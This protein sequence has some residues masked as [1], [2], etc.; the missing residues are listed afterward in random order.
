MSETVLLWIGSLIFAIIGSL[1][2]RTLAGI[3]ANQRL[4]GDAL[5]ESL[6]ESRENFKE[7]FTRINILEVDHAAIKAQ[8]NLNHQHQ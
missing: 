7:A 4:L 8:H 3:D 6:A 2:V 1:L 5:R